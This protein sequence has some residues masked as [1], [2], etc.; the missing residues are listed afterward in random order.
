MGEDYS[1]FASIMS[2]LRGLGM[3]WFCG[4][5]N[6]SP[7]RGL[8]FVVDCYIGGFSQAGLRRR[9]RIGFVF[10]KNRVGDCIVF[11]DGNITMQLIFQPCG[12]WVRCRDDACIVSTALIC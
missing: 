3:V 5:I 8:D 10:M 12:V 7:L 2:P 1:C 4:V 6:M 11:T 9:N